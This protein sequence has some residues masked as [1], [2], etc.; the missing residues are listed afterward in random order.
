MKSSHVQ[1]VIGVV[2]AFLFSAAFLT[3]SLC[4]PVYLTESAATRVIGQPDF[5]TNNNGNGA[6]EFK[7]PL[8]VAVDSDTGK[9]F[10]ADTG[11]NRVLRF[12]SIDDV[13]DGGDA[14][15]VF[16]QSDFGLDSGTTSVVGMWQPNGLAIGPSGELWV[17][18]NSNSRVL[19]FDN[20]ATAL[21]GASADGVLGQPDFTSLSGTVGASRLNAPGDVEV[22]V[23][24]NLFIADSG[25]NRI[26]VHLDAASKTDGADADIV[27]GQDSF[28]ESG[29]GTGQA[30]LT[31]PS[32]VAVN[33]SGTLYVADTINNRIMVFENALITG[34][35]PDASAVLGQT[36]FETAD[37]GLSESEFDYPNKLHITDVDTLFV[38]D[39]DNR[40]V[41][42]FYSIAGMSGEVAADSVIGQEDFESEDLFTGDTATSLPRGVAVDSD[43]QLYVA[44]F[45]RQ[46]VVVFESEFTQPDLTVGTTSSETK[47][48][49]VYNSSGSGQKKSIR[50]T[51]RKTAKFYCYVGNDGSVD[52][53][54]AMRGKGS[55]SRFRVKYFQ[56]AS[57]KTN[58]TSA[59][60]LGTHETSEF[61]TSETLRYRMDVKPKSRMKHRKAN[62]TTWMKATSST[63]GELDKVLGKVRKRL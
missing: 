54:C 58:V 49:D 50:V 63:D 60:K 15:A 7:F 57:G 36:D 44:D 10:V 14:E 42:V 5:T 59:V 47:G 8:D 12:S 11:N 22:D 32:G 1:A 30:S 48:S 45:Y 3:Q 20:A 62:F 40:R 6:N 4:G 16:G 56:F 33:P 2:A 18:E 43:D 29:S 9:I 37:G 31:S 28:L 51:K 26:V 27:I 24:G 52:E 39:R 17:S 19:R 61:A 23:D 25:N 55:T 38:A 34:D 53:T 41:L 35:G 46:R 13:V 21:S